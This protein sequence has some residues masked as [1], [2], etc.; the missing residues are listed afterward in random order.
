VTTHRLGCQLHHSVA[1]LGEYLESPDRDEL[2]KGLLKKSLLRSLWK[3]EQPDSP[4]TLF[5]KRV[6]KV[7]GFPA[8]SAAS[9]F[10]DARFGWLFCAIAVAD[11]HL[12]QS[13]VQVNSMKLKRRLRLGL[14]LASPQSTAH[15]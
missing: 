11:L 9:T 6:W 5:G 10:P 7:V 12:E 15:L 8:V 2:L 14:P 3:V 1:T 13:A 4:A